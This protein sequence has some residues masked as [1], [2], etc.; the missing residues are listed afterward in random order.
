MQ[1]ISSQRNSVIYLK[2]FK[3]SH[4]NLSKIIADDKADIKKN[5]FLKLSFIKK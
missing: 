3:K 5:Y 1:L 4:N 2:V